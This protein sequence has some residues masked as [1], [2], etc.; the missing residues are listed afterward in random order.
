VDHA[1]AVAMTPFDVLEQVP[2]AEAL[3]LQPEPNDHEYEIAANADVP[4]A[5][6]AMPS[7]LANHFDVRML[8]PSLITNHVAL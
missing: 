3:L 8:N 1:C 5:T 2:P 6:K 7:I 4:N